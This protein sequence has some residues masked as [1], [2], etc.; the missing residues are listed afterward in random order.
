MEYPLPTRR[1]RRTQRLALW[2]LVVGGLINYADRASLSVGLPYIRRDLGISLA[3]SGVLSSAFLWAYAFSQLPAGT[4]IDALGAR[5]MLSVGLALWSV[6]QILGG[7]VGGFGQFI[8]ARVLLGVGESPQFPSSARVVA[9][10]FAQR[11][12]GAATGIWNCSST[13]GT[14]TALPILTVLM[15]H[16]GWRWMFAAMGIIGLVF[17]FAIFR[18]HRNPGEVGLDESERG[19]LETA[20]SE[21]PRRSPWRDL[22]KLARFPTFWGMLAGYGSA[23]YCVWIYTAWLPQYLE[24]QFHVPVAS[25]GLLGS[26]PFL[27]GVVG[28]LVTGAVCDRLVVAGVSPLQSR[29]WALVVCLL[30]VAVFTTLTARATSTAWVVTT[31]SASLFLLYGVACAGWAMT[32]AVAP[33][34]CAATIGAI[35]N[36]FGYLCAAVAPTVTGIIASR[37]GSFQPALLVGA[38]AALVG[39]LVHAALV[40]R[41]LPIGA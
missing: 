29:K 5:L 25:A 31:V 23:M 8:G 3:Q 17:S 38:G 16:V 18:L 37:T 41:P 26:I 34:S 11:E 30:G 22:G 1:V 21:G 27:S 33:V 4:L 24:I 20:E 40:R 12:R 10:W 7:L 39:A 14:A 2:L 32:T 6:A 9:D 13:L 15:L 36:F 19:Y 28:S 35:Q